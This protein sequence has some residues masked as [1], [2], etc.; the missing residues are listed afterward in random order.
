MNQPNPPINGCTSLPESAQVGQ[1]RPRPVMTGSDDTEHYWGA[2][3]Y[4]YGSA[5]SH[6]EPGKG[7]P[8]K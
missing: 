7:R 6:F 3:L 4:Q 1:S 2:E 8:V 5:T